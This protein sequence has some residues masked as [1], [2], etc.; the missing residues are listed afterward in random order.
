MTNLPPKG[1]ADSLDNVAVTREQFRQDI[2]EFLEYVAQALGSVGGTY[3]TEGV[4]P[5][6]VTLQGTPSLATGAEPA[7]NDSS[8]RLANTAWVKKNSTSSG[9]TAPG[10][11][12]DG[13]IWVDTSLDPPVIKI[14]D[15][16][17]S[18]WVS[19]QPWKRTGTT[20][21]PVTS[22]D[23]VSGN[24]SPTNGP[25]GFRNWVINGNFT[26]NQRGGTRTPGV[27]VYGFDRW[28][29]HVGGLEQVVEALP[30]GQYTLSWKGGGSGTFG[31]TTAASPIT[32]TVT[33][34]NQ[35]VIVPAASTE[36]QLEA[37]PIPTA[38][39]HRPVGLEYTLCERY[40][41][42][43]IFRLSGVTNTAGGDAS[44]VFN[45]AMRA[46]PT[47][48][49]GT[50]G[51]FVDGFATVGITGI[52]LVNSSPVAARVALTAGTTTPGRGL[53]MDGSN[54]SFSA[55]L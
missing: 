10:A 17:A 50:N 4:D 11:P 24:L 20:V 40:F 33:A 38:F 22:T 48:T 14:W 53:V 41:Q 15:Q 27:G 30:A 1:N 36:V 44:V 26:V 51:A 25:L 39:E 42:S 55:E 23:T 34:A 21:S 18:A 49:V 37:G 6:D 19:A 8:L 16:T 29:G 7:A 32:A 2:G 35:S 54:L 9:P 13:Q 31:G 5:T 46:A 43:G 12:T 45:Q 47:L 3:T 52:S 28:K